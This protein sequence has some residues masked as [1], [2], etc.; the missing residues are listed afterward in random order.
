MDK[1]NRTRWK[2]GFCVT[3]KLQ[4]GQYPCL[5]PPISGYNLKIN[6]GLIKEGFYLSPMSYPY[7]DLPDSVP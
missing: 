1:L 6:F 5:N 7:P 3:I 4:A 2:P